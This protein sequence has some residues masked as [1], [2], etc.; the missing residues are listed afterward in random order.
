M[1]AI[2]KSLAFLKTKLPWPIFFVA[3]KIKALPADGPVLFN[4]LSKPTKVKTTFFERL[5]II[6]KCYQISYF[7]DC[8]HMESE[9]IA[10]IKAVLSFDNQGVVVECGSYK[11]GSS[12]KLSLASHIA[13]KKLFIFDSFEGLP[14]NKEQHGKNIFGGQAHFP[15]GSYLGTLKEVKENIQKFGKIESCHFI[16]GWFKD[17]LPNFSEKIDIAFLDVDLVSSTKT[18]LKYLYPLLT[19]K[20]VIFSQDGHLPLILNLLEDSDFWEKEVGSVMPKMRGLG[21]RKL[22]EILKDGS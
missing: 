15:A 21:K 7:V 1:S 11:G 22:V 19:N 8:P 10:V 14:N 20:G 12:A 13:K 4:F 16:K 9:L 6:L 3:K 2:E 17:T 18:C 5:K